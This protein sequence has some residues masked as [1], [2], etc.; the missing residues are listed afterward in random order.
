MRFFLD[1]DVSARCGGVIE[2]AGHQCWSTSQ[3][4]RWLADDEDQTIYAEDADAIIVTHD[5]A[6]TEKQK[7]RTTG[8]HIRLCCEQPDGP[9]VLARH[10][11]DIL[12]L[13]KHRTYVVIELK[14]ESFEAFTHW[15]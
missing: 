2:K 14:H 5:R 9:T 7:K 3:A 11:P 10:L 15:D 6:F 8:K 12:D 1:N 4:G 13:L